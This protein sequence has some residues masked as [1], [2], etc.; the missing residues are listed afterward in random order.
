MVPEI[1]TLPLSGIAS[2]C[3]GVKLVTSSQTL[4]SPTSRTGVTLRI[5]HDLVVDRR[6][7]AL[8]VAAHQAPQQRLPEPG[9]VAEEIEL[10]LEFAFV[11]LTPVQV[12]NHGLLGT[13]RGRRFRWS[14]RSSKKRR[15][16]ARERHPGLRA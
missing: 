7:A 3:L 12:A 9:V 15:R 5:Q 13:A 8:P 11:E 14:T 6:L 2:R 16:T 10:G 1:S 4:P